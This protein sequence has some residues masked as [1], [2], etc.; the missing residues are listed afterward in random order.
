MVLTPEIEHILSLIDQAIGHRY[1]RIEKI[2]LLAGSE[3]NYYI[4]IREVDRVRAQLLY[5][6][7]E[8]AAATLTVKEW[9]TLLDR[10]E[11]KCAYCQERPFQVMSHIISRS[12]GGTTAENCVPACHSC[13]SK[14][15]RK[16]RSPEKEALKPDRPDLP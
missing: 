3:E 4:I 7:A 9:F 2:R 6:R 10:F 13:I 14:A 5:A 16:L 15:H 1:L 8:N 12:E 11:W